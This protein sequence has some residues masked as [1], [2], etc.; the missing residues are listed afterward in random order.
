VTI[1]IIPFS[2]PGCDCAYDLEVDIERL[3]R[4]RRIG[5]C[6]RC[7]EEFAVSLKLTQTIVVDDAPQ[8]G[9]DQLLERAAKDKAQP[10]YARDTIPDFH[11][12]PGHLP[13]LPSEPPPHSEP[14][15][16]IPPS[17]QRQSSTSARPKRNPR[18]QR[19]V[20]GMLPVPPAA[21]SS[22]AESAPATSE[23]A[24]ER[25]ERVTEPAMRA[26][27][28]AAAAGG[29][30]THLIVEVA[31]T[32]GDTKS[33]RVNTATYRP[34]HLITKPGLGSPGRILP[35]EPT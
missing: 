31:S 26:A 2:C 22:D 18:R 4:L 28:P 29:V 1:A 15:I 23:P 9:A 11:G 5:V 19:Q 20:S 27:A 6:G 32:K 24:T 16:P 33:R 3:A 10:L 30:E 35:R 13:P 34:K 17:W 25:S 8:G 12:R 14:E 7:G 21:R